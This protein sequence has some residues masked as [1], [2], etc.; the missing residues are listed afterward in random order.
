MHFKSVIIIYGIANL[1]KR[2]TCFFKQGTVYMEYLSGIFLLLG[3][4]GLFLYGISF[5]TQSLEKAAGDNL[6]TVLE[7]MTSKGLFALLVGTGVTVLIQSSGAHEPGTIAL[8][9][10]RCKHRNNDN[11]TDY[12]FQ[13]YVNCSFN[14]VYRYYSVYVRQELHAPENRRCGAWL[15]Y[16]LCR[17]LYN[18]N[19]CRYTG[20]RKYCIGIPE[21][22]FKSCFKSF[23][24][25]CHY[26]Q[27]PVFIGFHRYFTG[28][29]RYKCNLCG[30]VQHSILY[31][32]RHEHRRLF[33]GYYSLHR[34]Q[35]KL[36]AIRT[37]EFPFKNDKCRSIYD[38]YNV[39]AEFLKVY[40]K[41]FA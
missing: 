5:M 12:S 38:F 20:S 2:R 32:S 28:Y 13:H 11:R 36:Q 7:K 3:G 26:R 8:Y 6:R 33:T 39:A 29:I 15:R 24:R 31:N 34:K 9:H 40:S 21:Q 19:G 1:D 4:I 17:N 22:I 30:S 37:G 25:I 41:S 14:T 10:A 35:H 18:G 27:Y 23:V 16:A